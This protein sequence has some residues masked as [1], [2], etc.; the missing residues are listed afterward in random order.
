MNTIEEAK[1]LLPVLFVPALIL[2]MAVVFYYKQPKKI[3]P[4]YGYRTA[5]S[6]KNQDT[7]TVA[8]Q[9][10]TAWL[11]Y[12]FSIFFGVLVLL[13]LVLGKEGIKYWFGSIKGFFLIVTGLST[14]LIF[15][16]IVITEYK[17][18]QIFAPDGTRK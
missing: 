11:L 2:G 10:S 12:T 16:P 18:K 13:L 14:V 6:M 4:W 1:W 5:F 3:N 15:V 17:L 8:N 7:W 9:L